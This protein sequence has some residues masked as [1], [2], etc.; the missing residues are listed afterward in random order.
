METMNKDELKLLIQKTNFAIIDTNLYLDTH[1]N[2]KK[3]LSFYQEQHKL[4]QSAL[5][6]Y[7]KKYGPLTIYGVNDTEKNWSWTDEPWPWQK[8]CDC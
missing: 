8:E 6:L 1:P 4:L 5:H 2:C 7:Q 3:A